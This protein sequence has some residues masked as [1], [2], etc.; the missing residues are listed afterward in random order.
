MSQQN[1]EQGDNLETIV[2]VQGLTI[3]FWQEG[4]WVNIVND[5]NVCDNLVSLLW[6]FERHEK[7]NLFWVPVE[8]FLIALKF[9]LIIS[10]ILA[11]Y[12]SPFSCGAR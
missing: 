6:V 9:L 8:L 10:T 12:C 11:L 2:E 3:D 1:V 7:L 5:V 4:N